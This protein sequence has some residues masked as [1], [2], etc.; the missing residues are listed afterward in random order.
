MPGRRRPRPINR[1]AADVAMWHRRT[2]MLRTIIPPRYP[3]IARAR[4]L[5]EKAGT[6]ERTVQGGAERHRRRRGH[7]WG[8]HRT[9]RQGRYL[10]MNLLIPGG[11]AVL[12]GWILAKTR[13]PRLKPM[14]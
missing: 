11:I 9:R 13:P 6:D 5:V 12:V 4:H 8:D 7:R 1:R 10:G 2:R 3:P 14:V